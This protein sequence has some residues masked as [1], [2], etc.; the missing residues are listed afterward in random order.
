MEGNFP[1]RLA[2]KDR[3]IPIEMGLAVPYWVSED[4]FPE[5]SVPR[6][7]F[8]LEHLVWAETPHELFMRIK[9]VIA[10]LLFG[11]MPKAS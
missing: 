3:P 10:L 1:H 9:V 6:E 8:D 4:L 11:A 7:S 2:W 5:T